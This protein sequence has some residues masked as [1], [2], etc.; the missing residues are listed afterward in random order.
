MLQIGITGGIGVGKST[1]CRIFE[2]FG[3]S[4]YDADFFAKYL[5]NN[6]P[7]L[8]AAVIQ[9]FGYES[10]TD[11]GQ[12]NRPYLARLAFSDAQKTQQLNEIVHPH[13]FGHYKKWL[14]EQKSAYILKEAALMYESGSWTMLDKIVVVTAPV[15]VRVARIQHRDPQRSAT[16]IQN[17]MAKQ[18]PEEEK[19]ARAD[20][21]IYNDEHAPL[22]PQVEKLHKMWLEMSADYA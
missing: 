18:M 15:E 7:N 3:I 21:V 6:D 5:M 1:V 19:I 2:T 16:E 12:L 4:V 20:Y 17:I 22:L 13:V 11:D 8:K 10:Y 9:A 14:T